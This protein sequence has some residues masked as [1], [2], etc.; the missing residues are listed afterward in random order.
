MRA[1]KLSVFAE[2]PTD[3]VRV[4]YEKAIKLKNDEMFRKGPTPAMKKAI[5]E[6]TEADLLGGK[7]GIRGDDVFA[8]VRKALRVVFADCELVSSTLDNDGMCAPHTTH[9]FSNGET[10]NNYEDRL[11]YNLP[12][13]MTVRIEIKYGSSSHSDIDYVS[14]DY[15]GA[16]NTEFHCRSS[17]WFDTFFDYS[18]NPLIKQM[19]HSKPKYTWDIAVVNKLLEAGFFKAPKSHGGWMIHVF[20]DVLH[21]PLPLPVKLY[22]AVPGRWDS[23]SSTEFYQ[24][25][26]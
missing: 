15:Y 13:G 3:V 8:F 26:R 24:S 7:V 9:T 25:I 18:P 12:C 23:E 19:K 14:M 2:L 11:V 5:K 21:D 17:I 22:R 16:S 4:I 1:T 20:G 6:R 10:Y